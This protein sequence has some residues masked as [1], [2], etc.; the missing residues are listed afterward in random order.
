MEYYVAMRMKNYNYS[1]NRMNLINIMPSER[2]QTQQDTLHDCFAT[3]FK[4]RVQVVVTSCF[5]PGGGI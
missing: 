3:K 5:H 1:I 4:V 2:S